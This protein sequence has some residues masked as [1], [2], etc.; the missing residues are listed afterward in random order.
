M[1]NLEL[2]IT[3]ITVSLGSGGLG[4][5]V[6]V[7]FSKRKLDAEAKKL[8]IDADVNVGTS[9]RDY[10]LQMK[11]DMEGFREELNKTNIL[12]AELKGTLVEK[13][14]HIASLTQILQNR[15]PDLMSVLS[16]IRT[17]M[18][19]IHAT[20]SENTKELHDQTRMM[21]GKKKVTATSEDDD[22]NIDLS[23]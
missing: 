21:T 12:V 8:G 7:F 23:R 18:Q 3:I 1:G 13:D 4:A 10:A 17:F 15:N 2:I 5:F 19:Q 6:T 20:T 14:K 16:D 11:K 9:W 22:P